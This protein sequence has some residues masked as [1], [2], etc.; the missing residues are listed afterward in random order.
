MVCEEA[1]HRVL[2]AFMATLLKEAKPHPHDYT[3]TTGPGQHGLDARNFRADDIFMAA[4]LKATSTLRSLPTWHRNLPSCGNTYDEKFVAALLE[5]AEPGCATSP[6]RAWPTQCE[7]SWRWTVQTTS[8][9]LRC[10]S[11]ASAGSRHVAQLA[12]SRNETTVP[13]RALAQGSAFGRCRA[14]AAGCFMQ[15]GVDGRALRSSTLARS[16]G[17]ACCGAPAAWLLGCHQRA[18]DGRWALQH[19]HRRAAAGWQQAGGGGRRP[20][21]LPEQP[22]GQASFQ[23]SHAAAQPAVQ[24]A[25]LAGGERAGEDWLGSARKSGQAGSTG[26]PLSLGVG[27]IYICMEAAF[28]GPGNGGTHVGGSRRGVAGEKRLSPPSL[29]CPLLAYHSPF[30][31]CITALP[32]SSATAHRL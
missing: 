17:G 23:R 7:R 32:T 19:Q 11:S 21:P 30:I 5:A 25:W 8:L 6:H 18:G 29:D 24:G 31:S 28:A 14:C 20:E 9:W 22:T 27:P 15:E 3:Y 1:Q 12:R 10:F 13:V 4:L 16:A 26:I 2:V